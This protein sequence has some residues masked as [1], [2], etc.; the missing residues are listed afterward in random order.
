M[1][2]L[3]LSEVPNLVSRDLQ[4][5]QGVTAKKQMVRRKRKENVVLHQKTMVVHVMSVVMEEDKPIENLMTVLKHYSHLSYKCE[6]TLTDLSILSYVSTN[7][8]I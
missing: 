8:L 6:V 1:K 4:K 5:M 3:T 2:E 7:K